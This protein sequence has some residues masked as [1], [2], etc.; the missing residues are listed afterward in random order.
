MQHSGNGEVDG[1]DGVATEMTAYTKTT[2][3]AA[4]VT[5]AVQWQRQ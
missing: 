4:T 1:D 3:S 2:A 5:S